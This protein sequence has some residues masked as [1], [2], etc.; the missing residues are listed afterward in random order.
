MSSKKESSRPETTEV[1]DMPTM[2]HAAASLADAE[3]ER[4]E[5]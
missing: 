5:P 4:P 3:I 1:E 2:R